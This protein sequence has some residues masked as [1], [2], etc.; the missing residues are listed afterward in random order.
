MQIVTDIHGLPM[1]TRA[2]PLSQLLWQP[3]G[4][5][6]KVFRQGLCH[7]CGGF[8]WGSSR[9][10]GQVFPYYIESQNFQVFFDLSVKW[11]WT[12]L[13]LVRREGVKD[14]MI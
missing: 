5:G 11:I 13:S 6:R 1:G 8:L 10:R 14:A 2:R 3:H 7:L 9:W 12:L 4:E